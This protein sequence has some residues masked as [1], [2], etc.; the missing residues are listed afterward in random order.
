TTGM[1]GWILTF[2][3]RDPTIVNGAVMKNFVTPAL[4]F[5]GARL[6][7]GAAFVSEVDES[8]GSIAGYTAKIA[9]VNNIS[10]DHKSL[11]EL[12]GLF[13]GFLARGE[14]AVLNLDNDETATLAAGLPAGKALTYSLADKAAHLVAE[15]IAPAPDGI[16]CRIGE[17]GAGAAVPLRLLVPG[18]HNIANALAALAAARLCGVPLAE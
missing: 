15:A 14:S 7:A 5:A 4:P 9:V 17:R 10:L 11:E 12:R 6:G 2:T 13:A 18:R 16:A 3:G 8:D 1:I